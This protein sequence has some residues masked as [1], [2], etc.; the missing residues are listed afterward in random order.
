[1]PEPRALALRLWGVVPVLAIVGL[2]ALR[3]C[4]HV[5][6]LDR[7]APAASDPRDPP[8]STV[9]TGS[10]AI[11]RGGRVVVG[12]QSDTPFRLTVGTLEVRPSDADLRKRGGFVTQRIDLL[13]GPVA[14]RFASS[15]NARI[16]WSPV[17]RRGDPEYVGASSLSP[18]PPERATFEAPGTARSDGLIALAMLAILAA[19]ACMLARRRL[20]RVSRQTWLAFGA[21]L[22]LALVA[23]LVGLGAAGQT[24]DEDVNWAA[25]RNYVHNVLALDF[26]ERSWIWNFE[27]PPV[28]KYLAGTGA[29]LVDG[30]GRRAP[31]PRCGSRSAARWWSRSRAGCTACASVCSPV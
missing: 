20:A 11:V 18:E 1:M 28:M 31:C 16:V 30:F 4:V 27:H 14:I 10:L 21:V 3:A 19:S 26:T 29:L 2:F 13:A 6:P 8:G 22:V 24:W 15:G 9:R 7:L 17:G 23:R 5:E 25:G 12:A